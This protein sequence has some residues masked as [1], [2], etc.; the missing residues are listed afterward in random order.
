MVDCIKRD[1][2]ASEQQ[3]MK[4]MTEIVEENCVCHSDPTIKGGLLEED[5][6]ETFT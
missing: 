6:C 3:K 4:S 1:M 5:D 2:R